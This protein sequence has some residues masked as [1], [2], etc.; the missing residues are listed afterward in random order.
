MLMGELL[1]SKSF[2][3]YTDPMRTLLAAVLAFLPL[4]QAQ[5]WLLLKSVEPEYDKYSEDL[6]ADFDTTIASVTMTVMAKGKPLALDKSSVPLPM[7]VVMALKEYEFRPQNAI[8]HGR[9]ETEVGTYQVTLNVPIRQSK[10]PI[11]QSDG[12]SPAPLVQPAYRVKSAIARGLINKSVPAKYPEYARHNRIEG[13][14]TLEAAITKQG[15]IES[16]KTSYGTFVLIEAAYNAVKQWQYQPYILKGE[17]V[18]V[19][20]DIPIAFRLN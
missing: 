20:T 6:A 11:R 12:Q 15:D 3:T 17:P 13:T 19:L 18:D 7:A 4:V 9:G 1:V 2:S 8:P 5:D 14:I 16:L 10:D